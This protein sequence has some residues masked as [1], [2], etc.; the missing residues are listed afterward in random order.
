MSKEH[1]CLQAGAVDFGPSDRTGAAVNSPNAETINGSMPGDAA[2]R[3]IRGVYSL[4]LWGS[5]FLEPSPSTSSGER[6]PPVACLRC[7]DALHQPGRLP[8]YCQPVD[9]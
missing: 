6:A 5:D 9:D 1:C 4:R 2:P 7:P 3:W 8:T